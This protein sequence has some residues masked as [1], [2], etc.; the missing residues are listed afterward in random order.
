MNLS[1]FMSQPDC[2]LPTHDWT[3]RSPS[4]WCARQ[5][6]AN[7]INSIIDRTYGVFTTSKIALWHK[8]LFLQRLHPSPIV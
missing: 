6:L 5:L 3:R 2:I 7:F 8:I 4:S 1:K